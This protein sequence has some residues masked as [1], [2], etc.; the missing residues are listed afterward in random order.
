[1]K[2]ISI[3]DILVP[4]SRSEFEDMLVFYDFKYLFEKLVTKTFQ[5]IL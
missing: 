1:M 3:G 5:D 4:P 2:V